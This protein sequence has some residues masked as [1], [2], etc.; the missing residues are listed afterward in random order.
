MKLQSLALVVIVVIAVA[1]VAAYIN[2]ISTQG[3]HGAVSSPLETSDSTSHTSTTPS[4]TGG[5]ASATPSSGLLKIFCAGSL[6]IP[7]EHVA[8][9]FK[10]RYGVDVHIEASGSVMAARKVTDLKKVCDVVGVADYRLIPK[11]MIPEYADWCIAFASNEIVIAF[12]DKSKYADELLKDPS[13]WFEILAR[14][15]VRYGFS[16]PNKDPCGYRSVGVIALASLYYSNHS[17]L[18]DLV[19]KKTNINVSAEGE[20]LHVYV[21]AVLKVTSE[22]L[23]VRPKEIDLVALLE[24]GAL[25]YAFEYKSVAVQHGLKYIELPP[26]VNLKDPRYSEFYSKVV[27]HILVG[28]DEEK[29]IPMAPIVYGV[30]IPKNAEHPDLAIKFVEL[31]ITDGREIFESLGQPFLKEPLGYGSVPEELEGYVRIEG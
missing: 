18:E 14:P 6:K 23:V 15:D 13:K 28:T 3:A 21:P 12:T 20:V 1:G 26:K 19:L 31:L 22:D 27:I 16:N 7:F 2:Y 24:A 4:T 17:I 30:T 10:S 11:F 9:V 29:E 8:E 25:D 5:A